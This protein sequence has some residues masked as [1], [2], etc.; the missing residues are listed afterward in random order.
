M[1]K[2]PANVLD[3]NRWKLT[4]PTGPFPTPTEIR[5]PALA[6]YTD[7]NFTLR[8]SAVQFRAGVSGT[9]Q[10]GSKYPR[11]ELREMDGNGLNPAS[12]SPSFG[13]HTLSLLEQVTQLPTKKPEVVIGQI[14]DGNSYILLIWVSGSKILARGINGTDLIIKSDY[15]LGDMISTKIVAEK[16]TIT[17]E[18]TSF[19]MPWTTGG[20]YFKAGCYTQSNAT[21]VGE[22]PNSYGEVLIRNLAVT[23]E[24]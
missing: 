19:T 24:P 2:T 15:V 10:T 13:R 23:H 18:D 17:V 7:P 14:H 1:P 4:L 5:Q 20:C 22:D 9:T 8:G 21:I 3:L 11:C 12:W 16:S 6:T